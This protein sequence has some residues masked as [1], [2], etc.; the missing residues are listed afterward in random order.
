MESE[1]AI[2]WFKEND[3]SV[4]PEKFHGIIIDRC[5]RYP[6]LHELNIAENVIKTEKIVTL[7]VIDIDYSRGSINRGV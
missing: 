7:L 1:I 4:N 2:K 3:M 6:G 5:G